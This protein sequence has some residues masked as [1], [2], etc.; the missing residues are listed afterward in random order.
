MWS[1]GH[2]VKKYLKSRARGQAHELYL[3]LPSICQW[4]LTLV[5][6]YLFFLSG[7]VSAP[8]SSRV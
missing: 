1:Q 5:T 6:S 3:G 8:V 7:T 2:Q 4:V